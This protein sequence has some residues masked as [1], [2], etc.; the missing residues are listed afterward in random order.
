MLV[1]H[2][3]IKVLKHKNNNI[4]VATAALKKFWYKFEAR[5]SGFHRSEK[6]LLLSDEVLRGL[7]AN[8]AKR[9][10]NKINDDELEFV[11]TFLQRR[12]L[13][14]PFTKKGGKKKTTRSFVLAPLVLR[15]TT[16]VQVHLQNSSTPKT[17]SHR[18]F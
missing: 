10:V 17:R 12:F 1:F 7:S 8:R 9:G 16:T 15:M 6:I 2:K 3:N 11:K 18:R 5:R 4:I 13:A 14:P